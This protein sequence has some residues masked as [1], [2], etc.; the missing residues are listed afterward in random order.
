MEVSGWSRRRNHTHWR[1]NVLNVILCFFPHIF[2]FVFS[3]FSFCP[4]LSQVPLLISG[5]GQSVALLVEAYIYNKEE[6]ENMRA[7]L[8]FASCWCSLVLELPAVGSFTL[9]VLHTSNI[10]G[11]FGGFTPTGDV[12]PEKNA[13]TCVGGVARQLHLVSKTIA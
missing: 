4:L 13:K 10:N 2:C 11:R 7:L 6:E 9:T 8:A 1:E 3:R 5:R 12:C